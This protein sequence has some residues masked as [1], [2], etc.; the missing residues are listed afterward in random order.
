MPTTTP[1]RV[2]LFGGSFDP[3]HNAHLAIAR[4]AVEQA[5]LDRLIFLPAAQSPLKQNRPSATSAQRLEMLRAATAG[6]PWAEVSDWEL[7]QESGPSYSWRTVEHFRSETTGS[8]EWFWLMGWDQWTALE[9]WNRWEHLASMVSFLVF[10]RDGE[11]PVCREGV[12]AQFLSGQFPGSSTQV[13]EEVA[14]GRDISGLVSR[15][16]QEIIAREGIY[17][18]RTQRGEGEVLA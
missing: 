8:A 9:R 2:A 15:E 17:R 7:M 11:Q 5:G 6:F 14:A 18:C 4:S 12:R 3:V 16:V 1:W 10:G 13:R